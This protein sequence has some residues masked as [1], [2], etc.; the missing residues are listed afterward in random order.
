[1]DLAET[2]GLHN[3]G[4]ATKQLGDESKWTIAISMELA[5][6]Y[7][8]QNRLGESEEMYVHAVAASNRGNQE[9]S[10][11]I[12][13]GLQNL[14]GIYIEQR[15]WEEAEIVPFRSIEIVRKAEGDNLIYQHCD[16][17]VIYNS[18]Q[19]G[20]EAEALLTK[21]VEMLRK[22]LLPLSNIHANVYHNLALNCRLQ[23]DYLRR[24]YG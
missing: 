13:N 19:K 17:G 5:N 24:K 6:T 9:D 21:A 23:K 8:F 22:Q 2:M 11:A 7:R 3:L 1:M 4:L 12:A 18:Q 16:L 20:I 10:T 14:A 15:R